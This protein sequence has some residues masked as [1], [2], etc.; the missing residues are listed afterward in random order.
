MIP[1]CGA[2]RS[3]ARN[4]P[5][6][7][8]YFDILADLKMT[9]FHKRNNGGQ[10]TQGVTEDL[11]DAID[12]YQRSL[13]LRGRERF[14]QLYDRRDRL[15]ALWY[16]F[17]TLEEVPSDSE[18]LESIFSDVEYAL[19]TLVNMLSGQER[20]ELHHRRLRDVFEHIRVRH[21]LYDNGGILRID[22]VDQQHIAQLASYFIYK[23]LGHLY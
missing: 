18:N 19:L 5:L 21:L 9:R 1:S 12:L 10:D 2:R 3:S 17:Q 20:M 22:P 6:I 15:K 13:P 7:P 4:H 23:Y 8:L 16:Y 14:R 11:S